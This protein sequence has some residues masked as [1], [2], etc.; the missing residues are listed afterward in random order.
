M[1]SVGVIGGLGPETT[2]NFYL[3]VLFGCQKVNKIRRP[4]I[5]IG[6]VPLEFEIERDAIGRNI[7]IERCLPFLVAEAKRLESS[8]V[9]FLVMP[10]NSLHVFI[11][12]IRDS[13]AI[14][15]LSIVEQTADY[16][17]KTG[18]DKIGLISTSATIANRVYEANLNKKGITFIK[19]EVDQRAQ[20]D[21]II[22]RL[23]NGDCRDEDQLYLVSVADELFEKGASQVALACTDLQLLNPVSEKVVIFDTM[24]LLANSTINHIL[25]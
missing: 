25:A 22:Q 15:V 7:G 13:V 8:G 3:E 6:S 10:C 16:L 1:K 18:V 14:P 2:S 11:D 12:E 17:E 21:A 5:V 19:P 4:L 20:I 9:D 23:I 24:K